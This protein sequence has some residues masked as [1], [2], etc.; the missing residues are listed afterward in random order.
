MVKII[1]RGRAQGQVSASVQWGACRL[2]VVGVAALVMVGCGSDQDLMAAGGAKSAVARGYVMTEFG[3]VLP[4]SGPEDCPAGLNRSARE[5]YVAT[6]PA[7]ARAEFEQD[8]EAHL[9][10]AVPL[11][12]DNSRDDPCTNPAAFDDPGMHVIERP[13]AIRR[14][15]PDG[16]L[17]LR[18]LPAST[19]PTKGDADIG[20]AERTIDN[21]YWRVVGCTRG[22]QPGMHD[23]GMGVREG[24]K[25]ILVK[26]KD[27]AQ[28]EDGEVEV[29]IYSS[30]DPVPT[31]P[32]GEI[33]P[34]ASLEISGNTRFH[35]VVRGRIVDDVLVTDPFD[36]RLQHNGQLFHSEY[37]LRDA[38]LRMEL[39]PSGE[40]SGHLA[41]YWDLEWLVHAAI[42]FEDHRRPHGSVVANVMGYTCPGKYYAL[43]GLA[44]GHPDP[45]SGECT[46]ISALFSF[47][48]IPAFVLPPAKGDMSRG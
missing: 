7:D 37:Y 4:G 9:A 12:F 32:G 47:K 11:R 16:S 39:H 10:E 41:G 14:F 20:A 26:I 8:P 38:R 45:E 35:N 34:G 46:S 22:Y 28:G 15:E 6:L 33:L 17:S 40:V 42:R 25:T 18:E 44:D 5:D 1:R 19:C 2:L 3:I 36:L 31:G 43:K 13:L 48:A 30:H 29:G 21:Q 27:L 24:S 23:P